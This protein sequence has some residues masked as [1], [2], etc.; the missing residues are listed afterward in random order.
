[1]SLLRVY[2][3]CSGN[4]AGVA[5][6][7]VVVVVVAAWVMAVAAIAAGV[8]A[9]SGRVRQLKSFSSIN[10]HSSTGNSKVVT[11]AIGSYAVRGQ[12]GSRLLGHTCIPMS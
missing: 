8:T 4:A 1:M 11:T 12:R 5:I 6:M 7:V 10:V 3:K 9:K 2:V